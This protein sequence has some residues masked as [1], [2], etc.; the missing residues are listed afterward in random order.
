MWKRDLQGM[1]DFF[2]SYLF[3][4]SGGGSIK[5]IRGRLSRVVELLAKM[6]FLEKRG[7]R[8]YVVAENWSDWAQRPEVERQHLRAFRCSERGFPWRT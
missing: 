5:V 8:L 7:K 2:H 3:E 1:S 4:S 6:G